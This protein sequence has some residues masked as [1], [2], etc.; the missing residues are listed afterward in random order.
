MTRPV[1]K[2][3]S[4]CTQ[5]ASV[6]QGR[7]TSMT[8]GQP[9]RSDS[10]S[11]RVCGTKCPAANDCNRAIHCCQRVK[12]SH[13]NGLSG[14]KKIQVQLIVCRH[15]ARKQRSLPERHVK[16]GAGQL[17]KRH[18]RY[19]ITGDMKRRRRWQKT[20]GRA[21]RK[22]AACRAER[23]ISRLWLFAA[24]LRK[25]PLDNNACFIEAS[26]VNLAKSIGFD[27]GA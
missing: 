10:A 12:C 18:N 2:L 17:P 1:R 16:N 20:R 7:P 22:K 14:L 26:V 6:H 21:E 4:I 5:I 11:I 19:R 3:E 24:A 8:H 13:G 27:A 25:L 9:G 23:Y 15:D